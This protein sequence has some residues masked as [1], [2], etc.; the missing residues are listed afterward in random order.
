MKVQIGDLTVRYE[1]LGSGENLLFLH[2][3]GGKWESWYPVLYPLSKNFHC[4]GLDLPGFGESE[5][6]KDAWGVKDYADFVMEFIKKL[7]LKNVTIAGH[8]FGGAIAVK[9]KCDRL[10]LVDAAVIRRKS[11][12]PLLIFKHLPIPEKL[13]NIFRGEDYKTAGKMREIFKKTV[14]EDL[15]DEAKKIIVP[16]LI[17]WGDKD[18]D[19]PLEHGKMLHEWIRNSK[20]TLLSNCGHFSY[21]ERPEE[22]C[23]AVE[24]FLK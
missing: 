13:R 24:E 1:E 18:R 23:K 21:L 15:S 16:T 14:V 2:G 20:F 4:V 19:T 9:C 17:V 11:N 6:P 5:M 7:G 3:W 22:F 8:S 10:I 12:N